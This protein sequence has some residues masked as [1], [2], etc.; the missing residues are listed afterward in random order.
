MSHDFERGLWSATG[1]Y[2]IWGVFPTFWKL[3]DR[4][5]AIQVMS[6]RLS[7]CFVFVI[8]YLTVNRGFGWW[9]P[10][11]SRP[12]LVG[13]LSISGVLIALNWWL[14]IWAVNAGHVVETSLGYF[15]NPL[16]NVLLGVVVLEERLNVLQW[17]A[18]LIAASGV[19]YLG[20]NAGVPPWI[21]LAL[22]CSFSLY[23]LIRKIA[24]VESIPALGLENAILIV[25]VLLYLS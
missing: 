8:G 16:V 11:V 15:I 9:K 4:L 21:A 2:L 24:V 17:L 19:I 22:A 5:P 7:W 10:F 23:G 20:L 14:Y 1:A 12:R 3:L 25:P 6:R 13:L 18:V